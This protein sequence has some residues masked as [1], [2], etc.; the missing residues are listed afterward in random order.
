MLHKPKQ[1]KQKGQ[2]KK[3]QSR[4]FYK[5]FTQERVLQKLTYKRPKKL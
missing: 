4:V 3:Q 1:N 2:A 5:I